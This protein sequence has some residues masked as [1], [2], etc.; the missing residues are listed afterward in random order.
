MKKKG[1]TEDSFWLKHLLCTTR[2]LKIPPKF[3]LQKDIY[4]NENMI[5]EKDTPL[6]VTRLSQIHFSG[7]DHKSRIGRVLREKVD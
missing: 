1:K 7:L 3:Y 6:Y 2:L 5:P 4:K